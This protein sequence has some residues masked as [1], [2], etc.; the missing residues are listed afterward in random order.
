[1]KFVTFHYL[2]LLSKNYKQI[3]INWCS[4]YYFKNL[5]TDEEGIQR[6]I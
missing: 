2:T 1:M 6:Y 3:D 5:N 4:A